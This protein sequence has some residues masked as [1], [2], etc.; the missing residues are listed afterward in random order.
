MRAHRN[1]RPNLWFSLATVPFTGA[2]PAA[3]AVPPA[4]AILDLGHQEHL[5]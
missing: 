5:P 2:L 3:Q 1:F 4:N